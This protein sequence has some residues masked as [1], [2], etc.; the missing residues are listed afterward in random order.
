MKTNV[1]LVSGKILINA[2]ANALSVLFHLTTATNFFKMQY[3]QN[4]KERDIVMLMSQNPDVAFVGGMLIKLGLL[5][6]KYH[7]KVI[8]IILFIDF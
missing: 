8:I 5:V 6:Q 3:E 7:H 1:E 4:L 2:V